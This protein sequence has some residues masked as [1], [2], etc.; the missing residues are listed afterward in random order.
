MLFYVIGL[1][2]RDHGATVGEMLLED[3]V[4]CYIVAFSANVPPGVSLN[5]PLLCAF[6]SQYSRQVLTILNLSRECHVIRSYT[7]ADRVY[8]HSGHGSVSSTCLTVGVNCA[9]FRCL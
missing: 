4:V 3:G 5:R 9:H 6:V 1:M 2:R 8:L 7:V